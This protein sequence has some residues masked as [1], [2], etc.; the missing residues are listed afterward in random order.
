MEKMSRWGVG[1]WLTIITGTYGAIMMAV[2]FIFNPVF[3]ITFISS[4]ILW[5]VGVFLIVVGLL[6]LSI[7]ARALH[8]AYN[9]DKLCT[10][11]VYAFCRNPIYSS[12]ILFILP[13][14]ALCF[15]SWT[16]LTAPLAMYISFKF[17]V[18]EEEEYMTE[19]FGDDY[20]EYKSEVNSIFPLPPLKKHS[21]Q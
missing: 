21:P 20:L 16:L 7:S 6:M 15:R 4:P 9:N 3:R 2:D 5:I 17:F 8:R 10:T 12:W 18:R 1:P 14:I 13:G 19:I 11:G